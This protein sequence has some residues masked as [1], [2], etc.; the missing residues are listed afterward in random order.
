MI[1]IALTTG[2]GLV[3]VA[4]LTNSSAMAEASVTG[5]PASTQN[6]SDNPTLATDANGYSIQEGGKNLSRVAITDHVA[7]TW[8]ARIT[9]TGATTR[10]REPREPVKAGETWKFASDVKARTGAKAHITVS[11]FDA[12]GD[13]LSW[14]GGSASSVRPTSWTRVAADLKVPTNAATAR[15]VV[16]VTGSAKSANVWVVQHDV[17]APSTSKR[18]SRRLDVDVD[19]TTSTT[20]TTAPTTEPTL[21]DDLVDDVHAH[22]HPEPPRAGCQ[23]EL[24]SAVRRQGLRAPGRAGRGRA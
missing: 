15:T 8:A 11:W 23:R 16:N 10:I 6:L 3:P 22:H 4:L 20:S 1:A 19:V 18:P 14:T 17:R 5:S 21:V 13:F 12:N 24:R 9:S 2:L 7:A